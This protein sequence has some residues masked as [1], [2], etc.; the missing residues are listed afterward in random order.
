MNRPIHDAF[1]AVQASPELKERTRAYL[2]ARRAPH[3]PRYRAMAAAAACLLVIFLGTGGVLAWFTPVSAV[4]VEAG[5]SLELSLN[6]FDRVLQVQG[7]SAQDQELADRLELLYRTYTDALEA[8]LASQEVT[9]AL[10]S[11]AELSVTVAGQNEQHCEDLL[12]DT[13]S[14]AEHGSCSSAD[15]SQVTAAQQEGL[16]L[17]KYQMLLQLQA[18]DPSITAE[19]VQA[20]SMHDLRH[21]LA[22]LSG[23]GQTASSSSNGDSCKDDSQEHESGHD[24]SGNGGSNYN[25]NHSSGSTTQS[26][27]DSDHGNGSATG[28]SNNAGQSGTSEHHGG[29][30]GHRGDD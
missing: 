9:Q 2:H 7:D 23:T 30:G 20:C 16:S 13:Q 15:W 6:R 4:S 5:T 12:E 8:I 27:H 1:Q 25:S 28:Q 17:S 18:L 26:A 19:Q 24:S 29:N 11:G 14:Y 21:W 10:D 22:D 3:R